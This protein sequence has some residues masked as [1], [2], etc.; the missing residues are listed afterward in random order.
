MDAKTSTPQHEDGE[1]GGDRVVKEDETR[2]QRSRSPIDR[3][4][5]SQGDIPK[6]I[7]ILGT[8][9]IGKLV[10][11]SLK[12]IADPPPVT[13]LLH[14][15]PLL[16]AFERGNKQITIQDDDQSVS[17]GGFEYELL[18][19]VR[20]QH[21]VEVQKNLPDVYDI[22]GED[23][24]PHKIAE[25][26]RER[27]T[28]QDGKAAVEHDPSANE[29]VAQEAP[30][31]QHEPELEV[32]KPSVDQEALER[33]EDVEQPKGEVAAGDPHTA[34]DT[35]IA[36]Y[37]PFGGPSR[38]YNTS[39]GKGGYAYSSDAIHN[40]IVTTKAAYTV[41]ALSTIRHRLTPEST[42]CFLQNGMGVVDNVNKELFPDPATRP[43]YVQGIV[44][45]GVNVPPEVTERNPFFAVHAG[46]GTIALGVLPRTPLSASSE[47]ADTPASSD[48]DGKPASENEKWVPSARYILR[49]LTR[50]PVLCA[51]GFTP[52]E[53]LQL[54]LE[55]L[56]VNSV[57]NPLTSL[58]DARNGQ[59]LYNFA[60]TRTMRLLLAETSLVIR[61]LPE[62][63]SIPNIST[64]FSAERLEMLV[65]SVANKT[66][67]NISSML[68]DV[69]AGRKTEIEFIN[70]YIVRR[71]EEVGV[72][73]VVN[74]GIMQTVVG[75]AMVTQR[76]VRDAV[77]LQR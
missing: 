53:L 17:R 22:A 2:S 15:Y 10:A 20:K 74:Y 7:H 64:R 50:T 16:K 30:A 55:K 68:A 4:Y 59:I 27:Q 63:Q 42:I 71:G 35:P 54:Q 13:L 67:D 49:T 47:P 61:S 58:I 41:P 21:G 29:Q 28:S 34:E 56:A 32:Q 5:A 51:V 45:H 46:H 31:E 36:E 25:R 37:Q 18:P 76:E 72:K 9:S 33:H 43:S 40:L 48:T 6:R 1:G 44:T 26:V 11:H 75:K 73:C 57:L 62:L 60:L 3:Q 12:G 8:G 14:R 65:V 52:T 66:K 38:V 77:P 23:L 24:R 39:R 69:R 19:E 70:G